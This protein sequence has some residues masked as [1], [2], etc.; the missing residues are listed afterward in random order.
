MDYDE[1]LLP[2]KQKI[3]LACSQ[4][5]RRRCDWSM[6]F[7]LRSLLALEMDFLWSLLN[8]VHIFVES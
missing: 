4:C 3:N 1:S 8:A 7:T 6:W 2:G 5:A